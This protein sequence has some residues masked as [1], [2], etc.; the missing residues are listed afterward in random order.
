LLAAG[1]RHEA[2]ARFNRCLELD[3]HFA[4]AIEA[5]AEVHERLGH[6]QHAE[7]CRKLAQLVRQELWQQQAQASVRATH[8]LFSQQ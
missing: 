5:D 8:P 1:F 7:E 3:P 2:L 6:T 4:H